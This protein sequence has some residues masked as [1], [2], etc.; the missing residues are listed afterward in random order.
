MKTHLLMVDD[1]KE[2]LEIFKEILEPYGVKVVTFCKVEDAKA[3]LQ[4][5][6]SAAKIRAI[7]S[8]LM[9]GPTDGLDFLTYVKSKPDLEQ[10]DFYLLTG[11]EVS[12]FESFVRSNKIKGIISKPFH[13]SKLLEI[14]VDEEPEYYRNAA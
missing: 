14:L 6:F 3:Y 1:N 11:A 4:N 9:M 12:V 10:I 7:V 8:D 5:P 13:V 2:I